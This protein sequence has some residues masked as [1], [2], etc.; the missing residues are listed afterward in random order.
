[1]AFLNHLRRNATSAAYRFLFGEQGPRRERPSPPARQLPSLSPS[2][3]PAC[4][5]EK[6]RAALAEADGRQPAGIA[7]RPRLPRRDRDAR[8]AVA[9]RG[10]MRSSLQITRCLETEGVQ[11]TNYVLKPCGG[12]GP[13]SAR[14]NQPRAATHA[15]PP[16]PPTAKSVPASRS[17]QLEETFL[18][19]LRCSQR[20]RPCQ[21]RFILHLFKI[22]G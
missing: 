7:P 3:H 18:Q 6:P 22:D 15:A 11:S 9:F 17:L 12:G 2:L 1:M 20:A 16:P 5:L 19:P 10:G 13:L 8:A 14:I 21:L 4:P